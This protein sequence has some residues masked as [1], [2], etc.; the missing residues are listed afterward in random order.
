MVEAASLDEITTT[1]NAATSRNDFLNIPELNVKHS[2]TLTQR[3]KG[4][5][6]KSTWVVKKTRSK[7]LFLVVTRK[8]PA[9]GKNISLVE[10]PYALVIRLTDRENE[11]ARLYTEIR[12]Q[13]QARERVRQRART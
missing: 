8:D 1:F 10:E 12:A 6:Q 5:I 11:H 13:L 9:W 7:R 4:T 2:H 3:S